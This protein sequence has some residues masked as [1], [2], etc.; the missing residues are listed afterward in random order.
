MYVEKKLCV[1]GEQILQIRLFY[2]TFH[3]KLDIA[4]VCTLHIV[5]HAEVCTIHIVTMVTMPGEHADN[6][7]T[8][9]TPFIHDCKRHVNTLRGLMLVTCLICIMTLTFLMLQVPGTVLYTAHTLHIRYTYARY[10]LHIRCTNTAHTLHAHTL[11]IHSTYTLHKHCTYAAHTLHIHCTY[12]AH[13]L[14]IHCTYTAHT[15]HIHCT[16]TAHTLYIHCTYTAH[17]IKVLNVIP[18]PP[19]NCSLIPSGPQVLVV[20]VQIK[21]SMSLAEISNALVRGNLSC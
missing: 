7:V 20:I 14:H 3:Y 10:T 12:T 2:I 11:H 8:V 1:C 9:N 17:T 4:E 21:S 5:T 18:P 13:T 19:P 16:Y 15:L 6:L